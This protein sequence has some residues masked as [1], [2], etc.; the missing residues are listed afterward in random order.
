ME[1]GLQRFRRDG[2]EVP[3]NRPRKVG[4]TREPMPPRRKNLLWLRLQ[5]RK[6]KALGWSVVS[7]RKQAPGLEK[8]LRRDETLG[9][10]ALPRA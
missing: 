10:R 6:K 1:R 9:K 2:T 8:R 3:E 4:V 7:R 5:L